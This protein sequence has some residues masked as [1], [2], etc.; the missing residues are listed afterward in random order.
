MNYCIVAF[1]VILLIAGTTWF[2][3]GRKHYKG[4]RLDVDAMLKGKVE[5]MDPLKDNSA[6]K[7]EVQAKETT[8]R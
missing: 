8:S 1:G 2:L 5:G 3:D 4:P 6:E 7:V